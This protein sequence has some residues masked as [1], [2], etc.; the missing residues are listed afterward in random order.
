MT[1]RRSEA[2]V[3]GVGG[4]AGEAGV[5]D[6]V[7]GAVPLDEGDTGQELAAGGSQPGRDGLACRVGGGAVVVGEAVVVVGADIREAPHVA[8]R[9]RS[10]EIERGEA[11]HQKAVEKLLEM[12]LLVAELLDVKADPARLAAAIAWDRS[13]IESAS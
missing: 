1:V 9:R 12:I 6:A 7:I 10:D 3:G 13:R 2:V 4:A 5:A 8:R 11:A